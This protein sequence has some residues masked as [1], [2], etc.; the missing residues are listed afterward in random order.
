MRLYILLKV[1]FGTVRAT[2]YFGTARRS[3]RMQAPLLGKIRI[4]LFTGQA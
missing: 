4:H 2:A 1:Y 3:I